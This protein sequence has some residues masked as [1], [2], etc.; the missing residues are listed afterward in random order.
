MY[1]T[2]LKSKIHRATVTQADL[3]Y[4]G[5]VTV[6]ETL[7]EAADLLPGEQVSIVDITNG[8]R[9]ETYVIKGERDSGVIGINGAAAHLVHPGDLVILIAYG[10]MDSAEAA[11]FEPRI[12]F[13]DADNR[14]VQAG[15]DPAEAPEGSGLVSGALPIGGQN[16][17]GQ[18]FPVAETVDA[19]RLDALLHA[20]S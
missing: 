17:G 6:D 15:S 9:L 8:A 14:I 3:H 19:A 13:V 18:T 16:D 11:S 20:E 2:M 12:V 7:M 10:Q 4:V 5:S 1:R